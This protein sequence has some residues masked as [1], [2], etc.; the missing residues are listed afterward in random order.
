MKSNNS[1]NAELPG[2]NGGQLD[3]GSIGDI[4]KSVN[5]FRGDVNL[6][7]KLVSLSGRNNLDASITAFYGS[8]V[9]YLVNT[10]NK[11]APTDILGAGWSLPF[12]K[13]VVDITNISTNYD[14]KFYIVS[15]GNTIPLFRT[16]KNDGAIYFQAKN[17]N[18]QKIIYYNNPS[19]PLRERWEIVKEDG[20]RY[21]YGAI[22]KGNDYFY[23]INGTQQW[24]VKWKNWVGST[25]NRSGTQYPT[26]WNLAEILNIWGDCIYFDYEND[27]IPIGGNKDTNYTRSSRIKKITDVYGQTV[28]FNYSP[29]ESFEIQL[30]VLSATDVNAF[31]F[32]YEE[33]FLENI[34]VNNENSELLFTIDFDYDFYNVSD[35]TTDDHYKK[36]YL[37]SVKMV[38]G[39]GA[40]L[41]GI[42]FDY[43]TKPTEINPGAI[44][45][46]TFP[47]GGMAT[48]EYE[49]GKLANTSVRR[50]IKSPGTD[51]TPLVWHGPDYV[52]V[53][54]F[55]KSRNKVLVSVYSWGGNWNEWKYEL[56]TTCNVDDFHGINS[57][58]FFTIYFKDLN[59]GRYRVF[60]FRQEEY[61]FGEW[62]AYEVKLD[63]RY[64]SLSLAAGN[65]FVSIYCPNA[66]QINIQ[67]WNSF[68]KKWGTSLPESRQFTHVSLAAKNN[69]FIF[70][71]YNDTAKELLVCLYYCDENRSWKIGG[72]KTIPGEI[73]LEYTNFERI[74]S[75]GDCFAAAAYITKTDQR[76]VYF[77]LLI[78]SWRMDFS[79][80]NVN[81]YTYSQ[82]IQLKNAVNHIMINNNLIGIGQRVLRYN[83]EKWIEKETVVPDVSSEYAYIYNED[84]VITGK[85]TG[86]LQDFSS[87]VYDPYQ[88][89]WIPGDIQGSLSG[90]Q[91]TVPSF[92]G[93]Y[94][95]AVNN[96]YY[97]DQTL[98]WHKI[99]SLPA[100]VDPASIQNRA[101]GYLLYQMKNEPLNTYLMFLKDG[102]VKG[103]ARKIKDENI[104]T[105]QEPG[106]VLAGEFSFVTYQGTKFEEASSLYIYR[107][108]NE[109][110]AD[111]QVDYSV[112]KVSVFDGYNQVD[113]VY[114]YDRDTAAYDPGGRVCQFSKAGT[115]YKEA[116]NSFSY[117]ENIY[118]NGLNPQIPG[119]IYPDTD[120]FTNVKEFFS[121]FN[122][123]IYQSASYNTGS[124]KVSE[125][126]NYLY[127]YDRKK[128]GA[129]LFGVYTRARKQIESLY[130]PPINSEPLAK[131]TEYDYNEKGQLTVTATY[132]YN[133]EGQ[134]ERLTEEKKYGWEVYPQLLDINLLNLEVQTKNRNETK[135]VTT[136]LS[137]CVL[138]NWS[139]DKGGN[140]WGLHKTY[141]WDGTAGQEI[142]DFQ[143]W[144]LD[145]EPDSGWIKDSEI[146]GMTANGLVVETID[147]DNI[148][149]ATLYD[150]K[151]RFAVAKFT[152]ASITNHEAG[153]Y[154]FEEYENPGGWSVFPA[155]E[156]INEYIHEGDSYTGTRRLILQGKSG[157]KSGLK[158]TFQIQNN[159]KK[160]I[161]SCWVKTSMNFSGAGNLSG[162]EISLGDSASKTVFVPVLPTN[163]TWRYFYTIIDMAA[164]G[165]SAAVQ[166]ELFV[167][168]MQAGEY[169]LVD[170]I[171]FAP[172]NST[173]MAEIYETRYK[174]NTA[175][176]GL[177]GETRRIG[178]DSFQ[179]PVVTVGDGEQPQKLSAGYTW[180]KY[181]D[182][183]DPADPNSL[184]AITVRTG[185]IFESFHHGNQW[186]NHWEAS[187]GWELDGPKLVYHGSAT[188]V[189]TL[190]DSDNYQNYGVRF[191]ILPDETSNGPIGVKI[192]QTLKLQWDKGQWELYDSTR[193]ILVDSFAQARMDSK[194]WLLIAG[195]HGFLFFADG[196]QVLKYN[197]PAPIAGQFQLFT[198]NK[199]SLDYI[200]V[201]VDPVTSIAYSDNSGKQIQAQKLD[202]GSIVVQAN[203][204]DHLG[205][206]AITTK[207]ARFDNEL[208]KYRQDFVKSIDWDEGT[209]T[210]EISDFYPADEGYPYSRKLYEKSPLARIIE[211][212]GPGNLHAIHLNTPEESRHTTI[213]RYSTN[214]K[215]GINDDLPPGK[216][217]VATE[218]DADK[219]SFARI[220]DQL[221][222]TVGEIQGVKADGN[223]NFAMSRH[224]FDACQNNTRTQLPN[225][226][227]EDIPGHE[228]FIIE[229]GY[230]FFGRIV[231][232]SNPDTAQPYLSIYDKA[233]RIRFTR[234]ANGA[235][236]GYLIY[237]IYDGLGRNVEKGICQSD[238]NEEQLQRN[239]DDQ[240]WLPAPGISCKR[241]EYDGDGSDIN[242]IGRL[243]KVWSS[244]SE[245]NCRIKVEEA[246]VYDIRGNIIKKA[247]KS[248]DY[249]DGA[250][251]IIDYEYDN[252]NNGVKIT[253]NAED[254][255]PFSINYNYNNFGLV[256]E[257]SG[258]DGN[259]A[260]YEYNCDGSIKTEVYNP[261]KSAE[262]TRSYTYNQAG[263]L[264]QLQDKFFGETL[265]Y[266]GNGYHGAGF[267]SGKIAR[268][269]YHFDHITSPGE[270]VTSYEY[271]Y[272]YD[273]LGRLRTAA[274]DRDAAWSLGAGS[275]LAY[276][277][278]GNASQW[279]RGNLAQNFAYHS[280][281]NKL[282]NTNNNANNDLDAS[283][284]YNANGAIIVANPNGIAGINYDQA[285]GMA[286]SVQV[287]QGG[288]TQNVFLKYDGGDKRIFKKNPDTSR[289]YILNT[290]GMPLLERTTDSTGTEIVSFNIYGPAG[291]IAVKR[292]GK[293]YNLI[294]DHLFSTRVVVDESGVCA[295]YNYTP[296][297]EFMG[298][299][300]EIPGYRMIIP[301]LFTGQ[302][303]DR[304]TGLYNFKARFY[305]PYLGR[306][307]S[308]DPAGQFPGPYVYSGNDPVAYIDP[309][310]EFSWAALGAL[311]GGILFL[312]AGIALAAFSGGTSAAFAGAIFGGLLAGAGGASAAYGATHFK[313][314]F[315]VAE[316]GAM[317]GLGVAFGALAGG[318][319]CIGGGVLMAGG[320]GIV[321]NSALGGV[322]GF[323]SNGVMNVMNGQDFLDNAGLAL[324]IGIAAS[325]LISGLNMARVRLFNKNGRIQHGGGYDRGRYGEYNALE[326]HGGWNPEFGFTK[327]PNGKQLKFYGKH[328]YTISDRL[329]VRIAKNNRH[330]PV[331]ETILPGHRVY[332]YTLY[333]PTGLTISPGSITV[334]EGTKTLNQLL[335]NVNG[336]IRWSACRC[337]VRSRWIG[338]TGFSNG[339]SNLYPELSN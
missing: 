118:F 102:A 112:S 126:V 173:Y 87:M 16:E 105:S 167:F 300:Y 152:N 98:R 35:K 213:T 67:Q 51:Y 267:Y 293:L 236:Q 146:A 30:P 247:V 153:Y 320:Y 93:D 86:M 196:R 337:V 226:F 331:P 26:A 324:G 207:A 294:K 29:K 55:S 31:Q 257:I 209:M 20:S 242:L 227:R 252:L 155:T 334:N 214:I 218:I 71:G 11:D 125:T 43:Y 296:F 295:A 42:T 288:V 108:I 206:Q 229:R 298:A 273:K 159:S 166:I 254:V 212:G 150:L 12:E 271:Q 304:E 228:K 62:T 10:W 180:R 117:T 281:T 171:G 119:V 80:N 301:Y 37:K 40:G 142:F 78:I 306:F 260:R 52:V 279:T 64:T 221:G 189:L 284:Q 136:Q 186:T 22:K 182:D 57:R 270:F 308:T 318:L 243:T 185:G 274:N 106:K 115:Y 110:I 101:P 8:N 211:Q 246:F 49:S 200:T 258:T 66:T 181:H 187:N 123:Q 275:P 34:F 160:F 216:Y 239:A 249:D 285:S 235:E 261:Q 333:P 68:S 292:N 278:N 77:N 233:G 46:I 2:I 215:D 277:S 179:M 111:E 137:V 19:D 327:V 27:D 120:E 88:Y 248:F 224:Y 204:Y 198:A 54:W 282:I 210:G 162:W 39:N 339:L 129:P 172:F 268:A 122:G 25:A 199:I 262:L 222:N 73:N 72:S 24:G 314:Q 6:P 177:T 100:N 94:C 21:I 60:L 183:F 96:I 338:V 158:N 33:K 194:D 223:D 127:A 326:G 141:Q 156:P 134:A 197:F 145:G 330:L 244:D 144:S 36:R 9:H 124:A 176:V 263:W 138:K 208:L 325:A 85:K 283:Y 135:N 195:R 255:E 245:S 15:G 280:G 230:D 32:Q 286:L 99:Y 104:Y 231:R 109:S 174:L 7:L 44:K 202:D 56:I 276:D 107:V 302:E 18:F 289:L 149:R 114:Q 259:L 269:S 79:L 3:L 148:H 299:A 147:I 237:W 238:W 28:N 65:D 63:N 75:I 61:R 143:A 290:N 116:E 178:Y 140:Q 191:N 164:F 132:N 48:F 188:G 1:S 14:D 266:T 234:D 13:I 203:C 131:I 184:L 251:H 157:V 205:R 313:N 83:G 310:G 95:A 74:W 169:M 219:N 291:M 264:I 38:N 103:T 92:A 53:A 168:N 317:T 220:S 41:P 130:L 232:E 312:G 321:T 217:I 121:C 332:N 45:T 335:N 323:V 250:D 128:D 190:K 58:D 316:W 81:V 175:S 69:F 328:G 84:I 4:G 82:D 297:G 315:N 225:Y 151:D 133:S 329:G 303:W 139:E 336:E 5:L 165:I 113:T 319:S 265:D 192:G 307:Y 241:Y 70:S 59:L 287:N 76:S 23:G 17:F 201:F 272:D 50:E 154:G 256:D 309:S 253:Y 97:R 193:G 90:D 89:R 91:I 305:D 161:L 322:E 240:T 47:E 170:D 311:L 163:E